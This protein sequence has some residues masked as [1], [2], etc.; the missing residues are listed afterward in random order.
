MLWLIIYVLNRL[1]ERPIDSMNRARLLDKISNIW[2]GPI[3]SMNCRVNGT[4]VKCMGRPIYSTAHRANGTGASP[5]ISRKPGLR[6][7]IYQKAEELQRNGYPITFQWIPS[8]SGLIGNEKADI[9]A[10]NKAGKGR[11][12]TERRSSLACIRRNVTETRSKDIAKWHEMETQDRET[13]RRG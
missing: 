5:Y 2:A 7:L 1:L 6:S 3:R 10:R 8:H 9:A 4:G 11:R 13:S 12:L